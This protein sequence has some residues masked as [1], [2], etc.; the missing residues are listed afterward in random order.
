[1][2]DRLD[3]F[4][5]EGTLVSSSRVE[6]WRRHTFEIPI[7][8]TLSTVAHDRAKSE[9]F[10]VASAQYDDLTFG[11]IQGR[12]QSYVIDLEA[13]MSGCGYNPRTFHNVVDVEDILDRVPRPCE[14]VFFSTGK[15]PVVLTVHAKTEVEEGSYCFVNADDLTNF[16]NRVSVDDD[17]VKMC[18]SMV[19]KETVKVMVRDL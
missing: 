10:A 13:T 4:K 9:L 15:H 16:L 6:E 3:K 5:T 12:G 7:P 8:D 1:M 19:K 17:A 14:I 18:E 11:D 2:E